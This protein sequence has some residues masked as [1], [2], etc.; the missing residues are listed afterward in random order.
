MLSSF[1]ETFYPEENCRFASY[2]L[3]FL[4]EWPKM[5]G[6]NPEEV[7]VVHWNTGAWDCLEIMDDGPHTPIDVYADCIDRICRR[8][9]RVFPNAKYIFAT[10]TPTN[11]D[12]W[13][14]PHYWVRRNEVIRAYNAAAAEVV[15][16]HGMA[17]NDL[18][19]LMENVPL[20]WFSDQSHFY[21]M[22]ATVKL[23]RQVAGA[24]CAELGCDLPQ[25]SD[26]EIL[27]NAPESVV[28]YGI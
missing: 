16:R 11:T 3:R 12:A 5:T 18:Y 19:A 2:T 25:M 14:N 6:V 17:V 10:T 22:P 27:K 28:V 23:T 21:T 20:D 8:M 9:K 26:E 15:R 24:I 4:H 13:K 1:A 7:D